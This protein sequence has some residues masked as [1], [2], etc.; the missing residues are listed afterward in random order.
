MNNQFSKE[1]EGIILNGCKYK[2]KNASGNVNKI[3]QEV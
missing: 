3:E 2:V 1:M